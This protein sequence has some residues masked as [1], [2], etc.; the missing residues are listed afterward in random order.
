[1]S[2]KVFS[3]VTTFTEVGCTHVNQFTHCFANF[4]FGFTRFFNNLRTSAAL[5]IFNI[6]QYLRKCD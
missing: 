1:M 2:E 5:V 4:F 3:L 6:T